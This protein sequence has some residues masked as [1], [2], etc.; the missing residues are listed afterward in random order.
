MIGRGCGDPP[1]DAVA[2]FDL[3]GAGRARRA[4]WDRYPEGAAKQGVTGIDDSDGKDRL[5]LAVRAAGGIKK[6]P[7]STAWPCWCGSTSA[8]TR[9]R[10]TGSSSGTSGRI[11]SSSWT[12]SRTDSPSGT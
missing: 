10:G 7:R 5:V 1:D 2:V 8:T 4:V 6:I 9:S 3:K 12:G 11:G